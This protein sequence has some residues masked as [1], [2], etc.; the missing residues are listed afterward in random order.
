MLKF[1]VGAL[2]MA[3]AGCG[4]AGTTAGRVDNVVRVFWHQYTN[5]SVLVDIGNN[6]S[7]MKRLPARACAW[8]NPDETVSIISDVAPNSKM[9]V[10]WKTKAGSW[11]DA[12][13]VL[14]MNIHVHSPKDIGEGAWSCGKT[15]CQTSVI[16]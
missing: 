9:W 10:S 14:E 16:E 6:T 8:E 7:Q 5:Y 1:I 13:C 12:D 15:T 11:G 4:E 3:L 2:L